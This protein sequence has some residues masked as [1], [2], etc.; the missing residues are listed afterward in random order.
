MAQDRPSEAGDF[1]N[2]LQLALNGCNLSRSQ[3][4]ATLGVHKSLVSRWLSGEAK[5]TSYN[6][7]RISESLAR[8]KPGF[9]MTL[10]TAPLAEFEAAL[11]LKSSPAS[12][13]GRTSVPSA[14]RDLP[15]RRGR[16][17]SWRF[18]AIAGTAALAL[19][20]AG[21]LL[22]RTS[23]ERTGVPLSVHRKT[24]VAA[25]GE[26]AH[27]QTDRAEAVKLTQAARAL[28]HE[29]NRLSAAEAARL[30]KQAIS[31]DPSYA[32][33]W[34]RLGHATYFA[35]WYAE[36]IEPGAKLR[37]KA[38]ALAYVKRALAISPRSAE[39]QAIMGL[40][41]D[42]TH[43][44]VPML[45]RA[46]RSDPDSAEAWLWL[47]A[48][49]REGGDLAGALRAFETADALDPAW[50]YSARAYV[51]MVFRLRG[52]TEAY[53]E[54]DRVAR[55]TN[56][57]N[58]FLQE[59][60]DLAYSEGRL[61]YS[62]GLAAAALRSHPQNPF[63]ARDRIVSIA[64]LLGDA[65]L[66][67]AIL[68]KDASLRSKYNALRKPGGALDRARASPDTWWDATLL[69]QQA[70]Q[71]V[72]EGRSA[73]L[74]DLYDRR[75]KSAEAFLSRCPQFC[76]PIS[77]APAL[78]VAL[79]RTGRRAD[80]EAVLAAAQL[81]VGKLRAAGDRLLNTEVSAARLA[82]LSGDSREAK[83]LL[84]DAVERGWKGQDTAISDPGA[85]AAFDGLS[86][87]GEFQAIV[88]S[89]RRSRQREAEKLPRIALDDI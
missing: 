73:L 33:A 47:G 22:W 83:R 46:V 64:V 84:R 11:G 18:G 14:R 67:E 23:G 78:V 52:P 74:V 42:D 32:P 51:E 75:F 15:I 13:E 28:M 27:P 48:A 40:L 60:A 62:A 72:S 57:Q 55:Q 71:L 30:L 89:L 41:L 17:P 87:D 5:P 3:F 29:R 12:P 76:N 45:E 86:K 85:D 1:A 69:G 65:S 4:S 58:W 39:T 24:D 21:I 19:A 31:D 34:A 37:V 82:A 54:L 2:R 44:G 16:R 36:Q 88:T 6:L 63:W 61:A 8:L 35:W 77:V 7:A 10:W 25:S 68:A 26:R 9:N 81:E 43:E 38:E 79:R 20:A 66:A 49:K 80:A 53:R 59:R 56:D 70:S 50:F